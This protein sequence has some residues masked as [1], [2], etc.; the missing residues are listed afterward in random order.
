MAKLSKLLLREAPTIL[1]INPM[2]TN[3]PR[4]KARLCIIE[5]QFCTCRSFLLLLLSPKVSP[6]LA[7][8]IVKQPVIS[9]SPEPRSCTGTLRFL[10]AGNVSWEQGSYFKHQEADR[11]LQGGCGWEFSCVWSRQNIARLIANR[12]LNKLQSLQKKGHTKIT[13][14]VRG[15]GFMFP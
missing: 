4:Q 11:N 6:R 13:G 10:W 7:R 2:V 5:C 3:K 15:L 9:R 8:I 1:G 14:K 12:I